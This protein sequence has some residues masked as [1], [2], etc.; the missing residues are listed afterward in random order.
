MG[1]VG[2]H[3]GLSG[4]GTTTAWWRRSRLLVEDSDGGL[5]TAMVLSKW[6]EA[7]S[8]ERRAQR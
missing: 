2:Q 4:L 8:F 7:V 6:R 5:W 1:T 3:G